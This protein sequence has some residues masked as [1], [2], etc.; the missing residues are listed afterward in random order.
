[1]TGAEI[2]AGYVFAWLAGKALR[3]AGRADAEVDRG[4]D[5]G[6]SGCP[7]WSVPS[8]DRTRHCGVPGRR[9][10]PGGTSPRSTPGGA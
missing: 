1:M 8:S 5:A 3:V 7:T 9:P 2:A 6:M 4:L 10:Q